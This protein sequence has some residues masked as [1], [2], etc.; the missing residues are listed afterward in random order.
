M[1]R[2]PL[3]RLDTWGPMDDSRGRG[4]QSYV[5]PLPNPNDVSLS[6]NEYRIGSIPTQQQCEDVLKRWFMWHELDT[7][8]AQDN[9]WATLSCLSR[10]RSVEE[11]ENLAQWLSSLPDE[12]VVD[13]RAIKF[14]VYKVM[15]LGGG[16]SS[17][18][19]HS[20]LY[21][22]TSRSC[23]IFLRYQSYKEG[24]H[25]DEDG[26]SKLHYNELLTGQLTFRG[27]DRRKHIQ[28]RV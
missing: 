8:Q 25:P 9:V 27:G 19:A 7:E 12:E 23:N 21:T 13:F 14:E 11:T 17:C 28:V 24:I 3:Q 26:D 22:R 5:D 1:H 2:R 6:L 20:R 15:K 4:V 10:N 16:A 18:E